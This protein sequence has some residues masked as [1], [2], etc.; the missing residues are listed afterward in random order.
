MSGAT[1]A[2]R[3]FGNGP[4]SRA[5][6]LVYTLLVVEILLLLTAVPGL[7]PMVLLARE[8]SNLP[9]YALCALPLGPAVSAAL[10]ALHNRS[11][12]LTDLRPAAA[13]WRGYRTNLRGVLVFWALWLAWLTIV[14]VGLANFAA[15]GVPGWWAVLLVVVAVA[16]T[17]WGTN[18]LV[19]TSLFAF[20]LVDVARLA[21]YF[22]VNTPGVTFGN[23]GLLI[24]AAAVTA[25]WSEAVVLVLGSVFV[26]GLLL[27]SGPMITGV[28]EEF[29]ELFREE[30]AG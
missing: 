27:S 4:L 8:A 13:F 15:A 5:A 9:L 19:I 26:G 17:L 2:R 24:T 30:S 23:A 14:A 1:S 28:R 16:L 29:T 7:V 6:A 21:A 22:L 25:M 3:H 10:F 11:G 18:A 20:R 12:D